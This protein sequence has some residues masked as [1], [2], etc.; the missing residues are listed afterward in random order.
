[1]LDV[2]EPC[3]VKT[4]SAPVSSVAMSPCRLLQCHH[5]ARL[6]HCIFATWSTNSVFWWWQNVH[7]CSRVDFLF[8]CLSFEYHIFLTLD[9]PIA[10]LE[11]SR[12]FSIPCPLHAAFAS[13]IFIASGTGMN[14]WTKLEEVIEVKPLPAMRSSCIVSGEDSTRGLVDSSDSTVQPQIALGIFWDAISCFATTFVV[15]V[16]SILQNRSF[17]FSPFKNVVCFVIL[18]I[19]INKVF[20]CQSSSIVEFCLFLSIL[21]GFTNLGSYFWSYMVWFW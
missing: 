11:L 15:P 10:M 14:L 16:C 20:S 2:H 21:S 7:Q 19:K 6:C 3:S 1:M 18:V 4:A 5:G 13:G 8:F 17:Q 12:A 9:F